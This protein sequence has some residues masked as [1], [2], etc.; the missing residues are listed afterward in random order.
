[1]A[2][3]MELHLHAFRLAGHIDDLPAGSGIRR[4]LEVKERDAWFEIA[5]LE[6]T[7]LLKNPRAC[8][9]GLREECDRATKGKVCLECLRTCSLCG[10]QDWWF[11]PSGESVCNRCHPDPKG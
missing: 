8:V 4:G 6:G 11:R 3:V 1:M 2:T 7:L 10:S 5:R 9:L